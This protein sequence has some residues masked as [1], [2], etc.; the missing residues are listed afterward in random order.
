MAELRRGGALARSEAGQALTEYVLL[1]A[2]VVSAYFT[3]F[4]WFQK[5]G[6]GDKFARPLTDAYA[7][8]YEYGHPKGKGYDQGTPENHPF[9]T[10]G[11]TRFFINPR[12]K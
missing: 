9:S 6:L 3:L 4:S 5:L 11:K 12:A 2:V 7:K 1:L 8:T 10:H